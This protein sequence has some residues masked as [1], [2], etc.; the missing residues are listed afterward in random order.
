MREIK[1]SAGSEEEKIMLYFSPDWQIDGEYSNLGF[2]VTGKGEDWLDSYKGA[3]DEAILMQ[4]TGLK[5]KNGKEI[6]EGDILSGDFPDAVFWDNYRGQW[7]LRNSENFDDN[8]WEIMR[9]NNPEIIG[10]I[11]EN[12]E[13]L[14]EA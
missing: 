10:N 1:F 14:E 12:A 9:D 4:Y 2:S 5:D 13:L 8:L 6:Y 7:M 11:H 3:K